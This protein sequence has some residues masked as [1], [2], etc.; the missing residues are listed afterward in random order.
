MCAFRFFKY[1]ID[2]DKLKID[3]CSYSLYD[4][5]PEPTTWCFFQVNG[6]TVRVNVLSGQW[7]FDHLIVAQF[8]SYGGKR[9]LQLFFTSFVLPCGNSENSG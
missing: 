9:F 3:P 1:L 5:Q 7:T 2:N 4:S 8:G 6:L